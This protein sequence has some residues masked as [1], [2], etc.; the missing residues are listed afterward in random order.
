VYS[1]PYYVAPPPTTVVVPVLDYSQPIPV[2]EPVE[3]TVP[4]DVPVTVEVASSAAA[5]GSA[6]KKPEP[7]QEGP[8][9]AQQ[10]AVGFFDQARDAFAKGEYPE[11]QRLVESAIEKLPGDATLHEF[12]ALTLFAQKQYQEAAA[13]IYAVLAAGPGWDWETLKSFYPDVKV[14]TEQLRALEQYQ[15]DNPA[16]GFASL[17]LAYHYLTLDSL[18]A[19][20]KQLQNAVKVEPKDQLS[21]QLLAALEKKQA[22]DDRPQPGANP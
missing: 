2:P 21:A 20:T 1:N 17:L 14:Y 9:A 3:V 18:D 15:R 6:E 7:A 16:K 12:R 5:P 8:A 22:P 11:A 4:V 13:A 10:E 19:A